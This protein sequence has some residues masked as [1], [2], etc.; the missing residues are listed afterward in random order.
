MKSLSFEKS[1]KQHH[2][3]RHL[4]DDKIAVQLL[5]NTTDHSFK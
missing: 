3:V 5:R 1:D 2:Q 4:E